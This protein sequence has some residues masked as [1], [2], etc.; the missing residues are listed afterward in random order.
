MLFYDS[1]PL[2]NYYHS[3]EAA[4]IYFT[5]SKLIFQEAMEKAIK[6]KVAKAVVPAIDVMFQA[7]RFHH[8]ILYFFKFELI[9]VMTINL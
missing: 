6:N 5:C 3:K 7:L 9:S 2:C 8:F 4:F 1:W